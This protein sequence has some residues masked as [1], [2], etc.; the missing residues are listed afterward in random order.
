MRTIYA[1][2]QYPDAQSGFHVV[3]LRDHD[4]INLT[5][6]VDKKREYFATA[7][8]NG[9][10]KAKLRTERIEVVITPD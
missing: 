4:G 10:L 9:H 3:E 5:R 2:V 1:D 8:L 7:E 6:F